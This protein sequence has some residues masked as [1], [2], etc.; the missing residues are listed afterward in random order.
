LVRGP[1]GGRGSR[2]G[3]GRLR[4][5]VRGGRVVPGGG[6]VRG[7]GAGG[8]PLSGAAHRGHAHPPGRGDGQRGGDA[9]HSAG[10]GPA[11]GAAHRGRRGDDRRV[12][13]ARVRRGAAGR[14]SGPSGD[15][16]RR[17]AAVAGRP[18]LRRTP[19]RAALLG[20]LAVLTPATPERSVPASPWRG[21]T[22]F[23]PVGSGFS[24]RSG[25][26]PGSAPPWRRGPRR[27]RCPRAG[28]SG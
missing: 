15:A 26:V 3:G 9:R 27:G 6:P 11:G 2:G 4:G 23:F 12:G 20:T 25:P 19:L 14:P 13:P 18:R 24:L 16:V 7:A 22:V 17:A 10:R 28:C 8:V 5:P 21:R 1:A